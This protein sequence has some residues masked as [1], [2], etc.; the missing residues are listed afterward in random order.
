MG[1]MGASLMLLTLL[2]PLLYFINYYKIKLEAIS[3]AFSQAKVCG[4]SWERRDQERDRKW[5]QV[6]QIC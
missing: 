1:L 3:P 6:G 5:G 2:L 4:N